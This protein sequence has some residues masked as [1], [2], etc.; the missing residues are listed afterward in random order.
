MG[1]LL[2]P[3]TVT[4]ALQMISVEALGQLHAGVTD[5]TDTFVAP[6]IRARCNR[7]GAHPIVGEHSYEN[8]PL[9]ITWREHGTEAYDPALAG[10]SRVDV[11]DG[12]GAPV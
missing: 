4:F 2:C 6:P 5:V 11:A 3:Q 9:K 7:P 8:G 1:A 12:P 10:S